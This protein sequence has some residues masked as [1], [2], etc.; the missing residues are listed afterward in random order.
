MLFGSNRGLDKRAK[1]VL[2]EILP[3]ALTLELELWK[4]G[5]WGPMRRYSGAMTML[6]RC[7]LGRTQAKCLCL[8][9]QR[10]GGR[11]HSDR[12]YVGHGMRGDVMAPTLCTITSGASQLVEV[13]VIRRGF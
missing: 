1:I 4:S 10:K 8:V 5:I 11:G 7:C 3:G 13:C 9:F 12:L 6:C 2:C